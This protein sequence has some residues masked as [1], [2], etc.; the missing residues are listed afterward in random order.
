VEFLSLVSVSQK[1]NKLRL[2]GMSRVVSM[3]MG[4]ISV[5]GMVTVMMGMRG[6]GV[7]M[8]SVMMG[9]RG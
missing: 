7:A 3:M 9:M 1:I 2:G 5:M 6:E 8:V 4:V